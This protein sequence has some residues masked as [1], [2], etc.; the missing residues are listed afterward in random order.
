M[1]RRWS[2]ASRLSAG[3][4]VVCGL[5]AFFLV[6]SYS[7]RVEELAPAIGPPVSVVVAA[8]GVAR[9]TQLTSSM[10]SVTEI[11]RAYAPPGALTKTAQAVGRTTLTALAG[12]EP[13]TG[14]RLGAAGAGPVA[15]LV[16]PGLRAFTIPSDMPAGSIQPGD[17]ID[18]YATFGGG[19]PHVETAGESLEVIAVLEST[20]AV[21]TTAPAGTADSGPTLVLSVCTEQASGLAYAKA[22]AYLSVAIA[23]PEEPPV[24]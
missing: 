20:G 13:I 19:Q 16:P 10:V 15:S 14:T 8:G 12:G 11:P 21:A 24:S 17:L 7:A 2:P 6:R 1:R 9:G 3:L 18:V 5:A 4:A 22:F 23:G